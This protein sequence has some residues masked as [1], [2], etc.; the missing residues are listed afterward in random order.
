NDYAYAIESWGYLRDW[1]KAGA[2]GY[3][4]WN[5]V[6]DTVGKSIDAQRPWPQNALLTVDRQSK[7]LVATPAYYVDPNAVRID[8]TGGDAVAFK[9]P[10]GSLVA[11][12]YN[13]AN[14][15]AST[16]VAMGATTYQAMVPAQGFAT[17]HVKE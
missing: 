1:L 17:L 9:N 2:N 14:Q 6:L 10:D 8:A 16:T 4:A 13:S 15:A 5:M 7:T 11:V 3:S 12:V